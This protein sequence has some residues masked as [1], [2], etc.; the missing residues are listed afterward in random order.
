MNSAILA[1]SEAD[2]VT[3][4][5]NSPSNFASRHSGFQSAVIHG[6]EGRNEK[7][8]LRPRAVAFHRGSRSTSQGQRRRLNPREM[9]FP[10]LLQ[11]LRIVATVHVPYHCEIRGIIST[12]VDPECNPEFYMSFHVSSLDIVA[13]L[14]YGK[15]IT[16]RKCSTICW[17]IFF[18]FVIL[19]IQ[20]TL[21]YVKIQQVTRSNRKMKRILN[22]AIYLM[23]FSRVSEYILCMLCT[24]VV[25]HEEKWSS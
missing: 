10:S 4:C 21:K 23:Y 6:R 8:T 14:R 11:T 5:Y 24:Q 18:I 22:F 17:E 19:Y 20:K 2:C 25:E 7:L 15:M 9:K 3:P 12:G 16:R 13:I 1:I